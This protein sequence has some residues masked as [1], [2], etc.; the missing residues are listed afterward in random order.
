MFRNRLLYRW[1]AVSAATVVAA[2]G[3]ALAFDGRSTAAPPFGD[4]VDRSVPPLPLRDAGGR[5]TS[6]AAYRGRVVVLSPFLTLC[7][8][9]CPLTTAA[10]QSMQRELSRRGLAG[11]V[12]FVEVTV[13][14]TRD[15]PRRLRAFARITR[16]HFPLLTGTPSEIARFWHF[17]GVAYWHTKEEVP[18][19]TD[20]LTGKPLAFDVSHTDGLF[21]VDASGRERI[22]AVGMPE[23]GPRL[24]VALRRLLNTQGRAALTQPEPGWTPARALGAVVHLL[25][26]TDNREVES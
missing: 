25:H 1:L 20:W 21:V 5:T 26:L 17:F 2:S 24:P 6:L 3:V 23:V 8:E 18:P 15:T 14:P 7:R 4:T 10:F 11:R 16:T 19:D 13:D 22:V 9:V 12:A